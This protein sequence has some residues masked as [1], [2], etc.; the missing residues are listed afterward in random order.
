MPMTEAQFN[1]LEGNI[2]KT[3]DAY[4]KNQKDFFPD[5]YNV[6]NDDVAQFTDYT[7][8]AAGRMNQWA[9]KVTYDTIKIGFPAQYRANKYETGIQIERDAW[10][11]REYRKIKTLV[12]TKAQGVMTTL[13]Y[14]SAEVF[15]NAFSSS[16]TG[17]DGAALC[18]ATHHL[19]PN[20]DHQSNT[21]TNTLDYAGVEATKLAMRNLLNDRG[22]KMLIPMNM[23]ICGSYWEDTCKKMFGS[24][25]EAFTAD[26]QNNAYKGFSYYIHPLIDGK[27]WFGANKE[28]MMGGAGLN[29]FMRRDP[30]TLE[31]DGNLDKGD[32]NTE[33]LS[34]KAIGRWDIGW[35]NWFWIY[36]NNPS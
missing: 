34:W 36:G 24:D 32:F 30:R 9:G 28:L 27:L 17:P 10:E 33:M 2:N 31:R 20:D 11:D 16:Y 26:N 35:T 14:A 23:V 1:A 6:I 19:V 7:F 18:S 22:D 5:L 8:G 21:G 15:N 13:Q 12:T 25:K 3:W 4:Y 29:L